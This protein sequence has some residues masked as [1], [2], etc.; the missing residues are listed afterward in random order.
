VRK[1]STSPA[2]TI[3]TT[4]RTKTRVITICLNGMAKVKK[5]YQDTSILILLIEIF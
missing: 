2:Q 4:A 1:D 3:L 5:K